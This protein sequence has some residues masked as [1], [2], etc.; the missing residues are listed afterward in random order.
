[1][2]L[3]VSLDF[4][5][6]LLWDR[7]NVEGDNLLKNAILS[8]ETFHTLPACVLH[9][10]EPDYGFENNANSLGRRVERLN[11]AESVVWN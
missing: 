11:L 2:G 9:T 4:V 3:Y 5:N 1:M 10:H 6:C 7:F 8:Q